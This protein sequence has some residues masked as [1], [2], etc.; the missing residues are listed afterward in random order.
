MKIVSADA[1]FA[2]QQLWKRRSD[3]AAYFD[4]LGASIGV[5][6]A[7]L[8]ACVQDGDT[9]PIIEADYRRAVRIGIGSTP[10]FLIG[11][12]AIVGAQP[13][14]AFK[15]DGVVTAGNASQISNGAAAVV[16]MSAE[17]AKSAGVAPMARVL[18]DVA[19]RKYFPPSPEGYRY[20]KPDQSPRSC[21]SSQRGPCRTRGPC[22]GTCRRPRVARP[23][24]VGR[25]HK[26]LFTDRSR[27]ADPPLGLGTC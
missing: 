15:P 13:F 5:D 9:K 16:V 19:L 25:K 10:S 7:R 20:A 4:S 3:A 14:E 2:T 6:R 26:P 27:I 23:S 8:R 18:L 1:V 12:Q 22:S 21:R 24:C 11:N 17:R